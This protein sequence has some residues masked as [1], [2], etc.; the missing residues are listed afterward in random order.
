VR[1]V[2]WIA[3]VLCGCSKWLGIDAIPYAGPAED[4][5]PGDV[6]THDGDDADG[7]APLPAFSTLTVTLAG[8][9]LVNGTDAF[10]CQ[11]LG[12]PC[13][14]MYPTGTVVALTPSN[15][16]S[17]QFSYWSQACVLQNDFTDGDGTPTCDVMMTGDQHVGATFT[18]EIVLNMLPGPANTF[19]SNAPLT[20]DSPAASGTV[21]SSGDVCTLEFLATPPPFQITANND[22]GCALFEGFDGQGC[23]SGNLNCTITW[24]ASAPRVVNV[25]YEFEAGAGSGCMAFH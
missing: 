9:G 17:S 22:P 24:P 12:L 10:A 2:V 13:T 18:T 4:G 11:S 23:A 8:T 20:N 1:R 14:Q 6:A 19:D 25:E 21:C 5:A 16:G 7:D 15:V 3:L